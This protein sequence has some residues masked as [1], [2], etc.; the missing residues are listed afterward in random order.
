MIT[1]DDHKEMLEQSRI[2]H[3]LLFKQQEERKEERT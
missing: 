1:K 2:L 3:K